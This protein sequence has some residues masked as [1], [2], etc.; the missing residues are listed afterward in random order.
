MVDWAY[1]NFRSSIQSIDRFSSFPR[2]APQ[3]GRTAGPKLQDAP[4]EDRPAPPPP[5]L[6]PHDGGWLSAHGTLVRPTLS[7]RRRRARLLLPRG[8]SRMSHAAAKLSYITVNVCC[9]STLSRTATVFLFKHTGTRY[10]NPK[11]VFYLPEF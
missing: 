5:R 2:Q 10:L 6:L 7:V 9:D 1:N 11:Q 8:R 4:H 3:R